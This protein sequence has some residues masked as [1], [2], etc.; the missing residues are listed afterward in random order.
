MRDHPGRIRAF[1]KGLAAGTRDLG[2][3]GPDALLAANRDERLDR[4]WDPPAE[5]W[6]DRL[7]M[8]GG[9]DRDAGG[10][11]RDEQVTR[12]AENGFA[13]ITSR[14]PDDIPAFNNA[15]LEAVNHGVSSAKT[16]SEV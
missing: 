2:S 15:L 9:R 4:P 10:T 3:S 6:P 7:G 5:W 11:W 16:I 14:N 12:S 8:V 1:L 13:L